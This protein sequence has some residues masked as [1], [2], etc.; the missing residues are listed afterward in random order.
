MRV[1]RFK[2]A[3]KQGRTVFGMAVYSYSP[4][5]VEVIGH[6]GFDFVF[7]DSE[8]TPLGVDA[9]LEHL[10]RAA[11]VA[12]TSVILR[13]KGNDEHLIRNA[14]EM[15]VDGVV[16]PHMK[17]KADAE[18]AVKSAKFPPFGIR[19]AA[20]EVRSANYGASDFDW[21]EYI[22]KIRN[23]SKIWT[24]FSASRDWI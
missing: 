17:V 22:Q 15:G 1:N 13:I 10:V 12:N 24:T 9:S 8:H 6:S 4:T 2:N 5:L 3:L 14:F 16:I 21:K 20:A 11:D 19:G 7:L 18:M 23:F